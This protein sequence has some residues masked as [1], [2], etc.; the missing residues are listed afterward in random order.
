MRMKFGLFVMDPLKI[1]QI[2]TI[3][4]N[5]IIEIYELATNFAL[6]DKKSVNSLLNKIK[7]GLLGYYP[8]KLYSRTS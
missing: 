3:K 8:E 6:E 4:Q 5:M 7:Y 2:L 1:W